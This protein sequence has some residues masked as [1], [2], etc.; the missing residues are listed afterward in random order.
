MAMYKKS[1]GFSLMEIMIALLIIGIISAIA[2]PAIYK[3]LKRA[4]VTA[5]QQSLKNIKAQ[6]ELYNGDMAKYPTSREG[7][8]ALVEPPKPR[9]NW[10]G[11][12]IE[13]KG[14]KD[15][16]GH[17]LEYNAPPIKYKNQFKHYEIISAGAEGGEGDENELYVGG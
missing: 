10:Q 5:T 1:E 4:K 16:W 3:Y 15:G 2:G 9:G 12:Y 17:E 13:E 14:L 8:Q 7:L 6:L 11:P